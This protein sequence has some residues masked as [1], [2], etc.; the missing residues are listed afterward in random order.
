MCIE[1]AVLSPAPDVQRKL[2]NNPAPPVREDKVW[3]RAEPA[4]HQVSYTVMRGKEGKAQILG[5]PYF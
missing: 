5:M 4:P 3:A 1:G 2:R